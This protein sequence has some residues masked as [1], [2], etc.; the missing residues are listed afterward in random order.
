MVVE[1]GFSWN[2]E[3]LLRLGIKARTRLP[4]LLPH[5]SIQI[6]SSLAP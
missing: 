6:C 2:P 4:L 1:H 5:V 3:L